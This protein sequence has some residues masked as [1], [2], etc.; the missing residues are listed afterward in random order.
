MKYGQPIFINSLSA[1]EVHLLEWKE[2][3]R[4]SKDYS[5]IVQKITHLLFTTCM[6]NSNKHMDYILT[7]SKYMIVWF[8]MFLFRKN[9]K[10]MVFILLKQQSY[11]ELRRLV[12]Y[13]KTLFIIFQKNKCSFQEENMQISKETQEKF[14]DLEV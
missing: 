5:R 2:L 8:E 9:F 1:M 4:C 3:D 13:F 6:H 12:Q 11:Q 7:Q 14:N 10:P